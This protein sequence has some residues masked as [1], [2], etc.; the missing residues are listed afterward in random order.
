MELEVRF[1]PDC[2][3]LIPVDPSTEYVAATEKCRV[4]PAGGGQTK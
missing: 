1:H 4:A 2:V 3:S